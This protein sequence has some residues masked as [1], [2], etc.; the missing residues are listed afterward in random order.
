MGVCDEPG[1]KNIYRRNTNK[2]E[3]K[4]R[5]EKEKEEEEK[6]RKEKEKEEEE[7]EKN[8]EEKEK[9]EEEKNREEKEKRKGNN[10][11]KENQIENI[12]FTPGESFYYLRKDINIS[13]PDPNKGKKNLTKKVLLFFSL[14]KICNPKNEHSFF[15]S[16]INSKKI[17]N[18]ENLGQLENKRG[19]N[20]DFGNIFQVDYFFEKEQILIIQPIVNG[21]NFGEK[22]R[23]FFGKI[24]SLNKIYSL[25]IEGIGTLQINKKEKNEESNKLSKE[26]SYFQF[27][28]I[29][30][31]NIFETEE[32]LQKIFYVI[33]NIKDGK[34][35]R[36]VYKS[37]EYDMQLNKKIKLAPINMESEILCDNKDSDIFFELYIPSLDEKNFIG[38]NSFT[39]NQLISNLKEDKNTK[40]EIKSDKYGNLG[41]LEIVYNISEKMVFED[42]IKKGQIN[43]E[44]AIDYTESNGE[45]NDPSSLHYM[46]EDKKNDYEIAIKSCADIIAFYDYDQLFPVYGFGG[47]P[48]GSEE[49]SHC[50]NIN[51]N[52]D[53]PNIHEVDNII[54]F[55]KE[56]LTKVKL[57]G[58]TYFSYVIKKVID[59]I[60]HDLKYKPKE[61]HYYILMILTDGIINDMQKTI[62]YIVEGSK[63]PLSI[64]IIGVGDADFENMEIL[65]G[66]KNALVD[67]Y[68][69]ARKRDIVQF[70]Q[71]NKFKNY[72][73]KGTELSEEVLKEIPR[74]VEEY[75]QFCGKF[76]E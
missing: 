1:D 66:D 50:F 23:I 37:H 3:E 75:Y 46:L 24:M 59:N 34:V 41:N 5:K 19:E 27:N 53:D 12:A 28:I 35:K 54:K 49:V 61:N 33:R 10:K 52:K 44:I 73:N 60:N 51:F 69:E 74:Q 21:K 45:P 62:D 8:R 65:D 16:I 32:N 15:I 22:I 40:I 38:Y 36:P 17:G 4:K 55:Y 18:E 76:Y 26:L 63:L 43:L 47:N 11:N 20:I 6:K 67:S 58:P 29:L 13:Y 71:F 72:I 68:G 25:N 9:E 64:V 30:N 70:V 57:N 42:F 7:E 56:S 31:N 48:I 14:K 2:E 39:L